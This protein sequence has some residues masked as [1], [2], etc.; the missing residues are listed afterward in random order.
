MI[1][2]LSPAK[3]LDYETPA[4]ISDYSQPDMLDQSQALIDELQYLSP[5][6]L[7]K[8][9]KLSDK[10]AALNVARYASWQQPF[11]STNA[12]PA[13]LAFKGD[14]Y[15]GLDAASLDAE[16]LDWA[17][18]HVR[19]LSGLYGLLRPLDQC[20]LIDLKWV[21]NLPTKRAKTYMPFGITKLPNS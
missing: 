16:D 2:V 6:D 5:Q 19:I 20:K 10:L 1:L 18:S 3:T 4:H 14:V 12:K 11:T 7:A 21:P 13:V 17:Q 8:L 9:M 15:T